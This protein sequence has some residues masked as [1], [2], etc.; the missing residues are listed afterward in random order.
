MQKRPVPAVWAGEFPQDVIREFGVLVKV[1]VTIFQTR[2]F[3]HWILEFQVLSV[4]GDIQI[5]APP[6]KS[7]KH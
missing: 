6:Q 3:N 2:K 5:I 7:C 4:W 1:L